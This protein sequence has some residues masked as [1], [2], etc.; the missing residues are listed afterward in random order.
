M[1]LHI[2]FVIFGEQGW[3]TPQDAGHIIFRLPRWQT[4]SEPM[5][6]ED[7]VDTFGLCPIGADKLDS[8][9]VAD[10]FK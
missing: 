2:P 8:L 6:N 5:T 7:F 3:F 10:Y 4:D 9:T 1:K